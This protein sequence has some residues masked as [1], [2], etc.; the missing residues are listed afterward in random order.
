LDFIENHENVW[1][2][3]MYVDHFLSD[4]IAVIDLIKNLI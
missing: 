3:H 4:P 2:G 1:C